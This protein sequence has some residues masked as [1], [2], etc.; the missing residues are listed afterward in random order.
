[1]ERQRSPL[2]AALL[3]LL[4][5]HQASAVGTGFIRAVHGRFVD[6]D[7]NDFVAAG[8]NTW[9][10]PECLI[11]ASCLPAAAKSPAAAV[12]EEGTPDMCNFSW[13]GFCSR[14]SLQ[15]SRRGSY[16]LPELSL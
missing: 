14:T 3:V 10:V 2:W 1:M 7:C 4:Q 8:L 12:C 9:A 11:P 16:M 13:T 6:E 5:F 15:S